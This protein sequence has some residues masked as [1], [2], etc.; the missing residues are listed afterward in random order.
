MKNTFQ[1]HERLKS[2]R[3]FDALFAHGK[4][5]KA[6]PIRAIYLE[7]KPENFDT[8]QQLP[9]HSQIAL[10]VPKKRLKKAVDRNRIKRQMREAYRLNKAELNNDFALIL[11]Y[12]DSKPSDYDIIEVSIRQILKSIQDS[13]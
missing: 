10:A 4:S 8:I 7:F 5:V 9:Q 6:F 13:I 2:K 11:I 3:F 1:P 12:L